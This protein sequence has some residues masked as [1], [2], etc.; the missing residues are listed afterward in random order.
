MQAR[1]GLV[2]TRRPRN[3]KSHREKRS[4]GSKK[5]KAYAELLDWRSFVMSGIA[6]TDALPHDWDGPVQ[7][8]LLAAIAVDCFPQ[9]P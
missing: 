5:T 9:L 4:G 8:L 7:A 2:H 1:G 3:S 6:A